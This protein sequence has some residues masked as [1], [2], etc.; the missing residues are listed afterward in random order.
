MS[1]EVPLMRTCSSLA[2]YLKTLE[3]EK[4]AQLFNYP[5]TCLAIFRQVVLDWS[6]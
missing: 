6:F 5:A 2:S 4:V 1:A 3:S